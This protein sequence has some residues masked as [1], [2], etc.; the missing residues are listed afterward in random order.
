ME[1]SRRS[2]GKDELQ[3]RLEIS[4]FETCKSK[5]EKNEYIGNDRERNGSISF[6]KVEIGRCQI[7]ERL[8]IT[9]MTYWKTDGWIPSWS[10]ESGLGLGMCSSNELLSDTYG[11]DLGNPILRTLA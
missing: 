2:T 3:T 7:L 1:Y 11:T 6:P 9:C 5:A 4:S 10:G 8:R